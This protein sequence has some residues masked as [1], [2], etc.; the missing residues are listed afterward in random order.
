MDWRS[1]NKHVATPVSEQSEGGMFVIIHEALTMEAVERLIIP[2]PE[3]PAS[4]QDKMLFELLLKIAGGS[5]AS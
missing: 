4:S 5:D 3:T 1:V 2:S